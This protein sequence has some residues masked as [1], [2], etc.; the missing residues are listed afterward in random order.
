MTKKQASV[1]SYYPSHSY[2]FETITSQAK[3]L[4]QQLV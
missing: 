4:H 2:P 1:D 3:V